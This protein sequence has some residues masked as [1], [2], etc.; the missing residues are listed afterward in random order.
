MQKLSGKIERILLLAALIRDEIRA[1]EQG[2]F[3]KRKEKLQTVSVVGAT[4][5]SSNSSLLQGQ[6]FDVVVIDEACQVIEPLCILPLI[7]SEARSSIPR[8]EKC[9]EISHRYL[10]AAGDPCQLPAVVS[11]PSETKSM[12]CGI[13][14]SLFCRLRKLG[15]KSFL[16]RKQYR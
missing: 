16:L 15:H 10:I 11:L 9:S 4:C 2:S 12:G 13:A 5:S 7:K 14:R 3:H 8:R 6:T 1:W